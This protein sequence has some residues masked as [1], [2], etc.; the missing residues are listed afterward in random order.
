MFDKL[1]SKDAEA[2]LADE[3]HDG[4]LKRKRCELRAKTQMAPSQ[5]PTTVTLVNVR[6]GKKN[7]QTIHEGLRVLLDT[8]CSDSLLL[9]E[10]V[11]KNKKIKKDSKYATGGG[12]VKT[13]Y[14]TKVNFS[15]PEFSDKKVVT[16]KFKVFESTTL[17]YDMVIGRDIMA[18]LGID[19]SFNKK[20]MIWE[21]IE[22]PMR[23][24]NKLRK[25]QLNKKELQAFIS[26]SKEPVV[27]QKATDRIIKILD[28]NY[29]KA[30]LRQVANKAT[31]LTSRE[32][33]R[34][35]MNYSSN[36]R[37][38]LMG[39]LETGRRIQLN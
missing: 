18:E 7:R 15:L 16:W 12:T 31:H 24:F 35:C 2:F 9:A 33:E 8:G 30:D 3:V 36:I 22:I 26:E 25:Y 10:Y 21:G 38:Y 1:I 29:K 27:T 39:T 14:E 32:R 20:T 5:R 28:A 17:G 23:D 34:C 37:T 4:S 11:K 13:R 6:G 19:L